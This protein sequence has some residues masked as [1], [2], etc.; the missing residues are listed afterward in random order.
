V[1]IRR[2]LAVFL[3]I[4]ALLYVGG[5]WAQET[6]ESPESTDAPEAAE[7]PDKAE[8]QE[9]AEAPAQTVEPP[10]PVYE[11]TVDFEFVKKT[12]LDGQAGQVEI[13]SVEF[14]SA[15]GKGGLFSSAD[16]ELVAG[17]VVKLECATQAEKKQKIDIVYEFLDSEGELIDRVKDGKSFKKGTKT[18]ETTHRTLKYVVPL[19]AQ[20]RITT[21]ASGE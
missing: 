9:E 1:R 14:A 6:P 17:V 2:A 15:S 11:T 4:G 8:A 19:I 12:A 10:G 18:F 7:A 5:S 3:A 16:P 13:R 20:V 21:T